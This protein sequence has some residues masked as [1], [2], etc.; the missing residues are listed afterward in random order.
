M[1]LLCAECHF[2]KPKNEQENGYLRINDT[3]SSFNDLVYKNI[4]NSS[5][6]KSYAFIEAINEEIPEKYQQIYYTSHTLQK[7]HH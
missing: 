6:S 3:E 2:E 4:I 1:Q 7:N 5:L